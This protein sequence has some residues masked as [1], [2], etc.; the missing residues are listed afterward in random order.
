MADWRHLA[1]DDRRTYLIGE[2]VRADVLLE[3]ESRGVFN[4]LARSLREASRTAPHDLARVLD[5]ILDVLKL[6]TL[7]HYPRELVRQAVIFAFFQPI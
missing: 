5:G 2:I 4:I 3:I 7:D 6:V 1:P